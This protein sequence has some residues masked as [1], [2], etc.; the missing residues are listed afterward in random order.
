MTTSP[1]CHSSKTAS[2]AATLS[3]IAPRCAGMCAAWATSR[4]EASKSAQ[5]KSRRSLMLGE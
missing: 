5:E 4:P 1:G 2:A 3:G